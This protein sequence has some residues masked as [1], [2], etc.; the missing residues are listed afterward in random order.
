MSPLPCCRGRTGLH[1]AAQFDD[2]EAA[3]L[4]LENRADVNVTDISGLGLGMNV[5][6]V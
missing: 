5:F 6:Q 2:K 4:L 3:E 1:I